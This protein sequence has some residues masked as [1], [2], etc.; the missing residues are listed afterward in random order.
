MTT[1]KINQGVKPFIEEKRERDK[2]GIVSIVQDEM[3]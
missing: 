3:D 1:A 2:E